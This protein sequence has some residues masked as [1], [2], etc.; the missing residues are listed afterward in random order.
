MVDP[1][2]GSGISWWLELGAGAQAWRRTHLKKLPPQNRF[3]I[4][5]AKTKTFAQPTL[6]QQQTTPSHNCLPQTQSRRAKR[7]SVGR[8]LLSGHSCSFVLA[9]RRSFAAFLSCRFFFFPSS[10]TGAMQ[11]PLVDSTRPKPHKMPAAVSLSMRKT[12]NLFHWSR[13]R[14]KPGPRQPVLS[15]LLM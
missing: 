13:G 15:T 10:S 14:T 8:G 11:N 5:R 12:A 6:R 2:S 3:R 9:A 1:D 7:R 4:F